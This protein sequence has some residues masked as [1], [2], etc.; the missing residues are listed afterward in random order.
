MSPEECTVEILVDG[1]NGQF[2]LRI[3]VNGL[4]TR[5]WLYVDSVVAGDAIKTQL[6]EIVQDVYSEGFSRG[7]EAAQSVFRDA[8]GLISDPSFKM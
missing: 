2:W 6:A 4:E 5:Y 1:E 3:F 8:L 7:F